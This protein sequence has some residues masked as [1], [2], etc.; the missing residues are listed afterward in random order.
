MTDATHTRRAF[1]SSVGALSAAGL[2]PRR[3]VASADLSTL[4]R[5]VRGAPGLASALNDFTF[6]PGLV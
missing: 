5:G 6:S 1:L 3:S 4:A 2:V